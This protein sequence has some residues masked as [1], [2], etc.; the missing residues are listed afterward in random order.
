MIVKKQVNG[1]A[2]QIA[3][4]DIERHETDDKS[5]QRSDSVL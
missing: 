3:E 1:Q 4:C 5:V 2:G